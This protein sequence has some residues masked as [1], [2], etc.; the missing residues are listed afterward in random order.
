MNLAKLEQSEMDKINVDWPPLAS[1]LKSAITCL[2]LP[3][4][5]SVSNPHTCE[6]GFVNG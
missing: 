4:S 5:S 1:P 6:T 2:L 3:K